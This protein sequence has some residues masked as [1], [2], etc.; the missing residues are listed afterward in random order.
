VSR[1]RP[2]FLPGAPNWLTKFVVSEVVAERP[3][4][5]PAPRRGP[6]PLPAGLSAVMGVRGIPPPGGEQ[7]EPGDKAPESLSR[8]AKLGVDGSR[9]EAARGVRGIP[10]PGGEHSEP[11]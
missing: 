2:G 5:K 11:K 9:S 6:R 4:G 10:T 8:S 7:S 1:R 3:S